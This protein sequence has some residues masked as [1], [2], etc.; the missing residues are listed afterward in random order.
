MLT[1]DLQVEINQAGVLRQIDCYEGSDY[2]EEIVEEYEEILEEMLSLCEPVLL[3]ERGTIP[4]ELATEDM[5]VGTPVLMLLYSI[6]GGISAYSTKSFAE[7]DYVKGMLADAM[8]DSALFS[9]EKDFLPYL[10]EFCA[11]TKMGISRRLEAPHQIPMKA[12]KFIWEKTRARELC[13]IGISSGFMLDPVKS[14]TILYV[15]TKDEEKF[16]YQHDCRT[17]DNYKCKMRHVPDVPVQVKDGDRDFSIMIK[18]RESLLDALMRYDSSYTAVCGGAGKCG[19]C[20]I[21]VIEG[22]LPVTSFDKACFTEEE[23]RSG[24]RLSCKAYPIDALTVE[25]NFKNESKFM[26]VTDFE[27]EKQAGV[28]ADSDGQF[29]IAIDIGTTT[30]AVQLLNLNNGDKLL[31]HTRINH[32]RNF[33]ADVI[34][35]MKASVE[36]K[37]DELQA[38]I[39]KDLDE[40]IRYVVNQSG[41]SAEN[42]TEV[43]IAGNT[44][45]THLLMGYDCKTLGEYPF[46]PVN[47]ELIEDTYEHMIGND[48]LKA[49]VRILPGISTFV[50]GDIVS[51]LYSCDVDEKEEYA[52]LIDLGTNGEIALGNKT[53]LM[54]TSTAAG[55]A[56]EGGNIEWGIGS[57]EGAIAGVTLTEDGPKIR[58]IGD[59]TPTGICGTGVVEMVAELVRTELV[60]E[61]GCLDDD[62]FDDGYPLAKTADGEDIVF[63]QQDVREIQLAKAAVR[64][65][66]ETLILRYGIEKEDIAQVYLAGGFGFKLDCQ[67]AI[68]IGMIPEEFAGKIEA[69]GNSSLGGAVKCLLSKNGWERTTA[70]GSRAREINLSADKD[71]NHFYMEYMY[72]EC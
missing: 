35:R 65:G 20:K 31:T 40:G 23:L 26:V 17:C 19:K 61:T 24:I 28:Q 49:R 9:M 56:F 21:R 1:R 68:A 71:F 62:Y 58:T 34:S 55:P 29:G 33:G 30:I 2:Y 46:T 13:G 5:P 7:G 37:K 54:A 3:M 15:L 39:R 52:L 51:G 67:K 18:D 38:S 32:Q 57:I 8:A 63:T 48:F 69:I 42:V 47:I 43:A 6:G 60:D 25:L 36:G 10:K 44:T 16:Q 70:M 66:I 12:Q 27:Q 14:N 22:K 4:K 41:V 45:M 50:G 72:F 59:K 11:E 64:A 53:K